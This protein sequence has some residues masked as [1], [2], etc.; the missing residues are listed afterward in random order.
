MTPLSQPITSCAGTY[1]GTDFAEAPRPS[2][3]FPW[4]CCSSSWLPSSRLL[5]HNLPPAVEAGIC[6]FPQ[7]SHTASIF[8]K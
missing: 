5:L 2:T 6:T 4:P 3:A 1:S 7:V 8:K